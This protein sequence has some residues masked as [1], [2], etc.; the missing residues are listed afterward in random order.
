MPT[1]VCTLQ[2]ISACMCVCACVCIRSSAVLRNFFRGGGGA[3]L[4]LQK[5]RREKSGYKIS[6]IQ[7]GLSKGGARI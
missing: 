7:A 2:A 6:V 3:S 5:I 1:H 4:R